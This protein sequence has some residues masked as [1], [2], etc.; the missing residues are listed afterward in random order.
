MEPAELARILELLPVSRCVLILRPLDK[1]EQ[2]VMVGLLPSTTAPWVE[3]LLR[4][5]KDSAGF[6]AEPARAVLSPEMSVGEARQLIGGIVGS[7]VYVVDGDNRLVGV[8]HQ[9]QLAASDP[10]ALV[11]NLMSAKVT[12]IPSAAPL[13]AIRDHQA[14]FDFDRLPVVDG[15]G[16]LVGVIRHR[17]VRR[18]GRALRAAPTS[19]GPVLNT[20]LE[21]GELFW[22][23]L[24]SVVAA[25][26]NREPMEESTEVE[27]DA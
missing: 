27:R 11:G 14:W 24:T 21:L 10:R 15:S 6:L 8:V 23:G 9:R 5:S 1:E 12:R 26:A 19:H 7:S 4:S 13:S 22:G 3:R 18:S 16:V 2:T 17:S 25:T 20:F